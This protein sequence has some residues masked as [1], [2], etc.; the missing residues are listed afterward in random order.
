M[1]Y[2]LQRNFKIGDVI[3]FNDG[4]D[5]KV[6][7][8]A[9]T[10]LHNGYHGLADLQLYLVKYNNK[11][12]YASDNGLDSRDPW[13]FKEVIAGIGYRGNINYKSFKKE[14]NIWKDIIYRCYN[15]NS[16]LYPYYGG[17]EVTV[18]NKW[19]CFEIFL[20]DIINLK[21]Y[22][23]MIRDKSNTVWDLDI[24]KQRDIPINQ[25]S[26]NPKGVKLE[27]FFCTDAGAVLKRLR[28]VGNNSDANSINSYQDNPVKPAEPKKYEPLSDS[29]YPLEA[30]TAVINNPPDLPI[31]DMEVLPPG[32][33]RTFMGFHYDNRPPIKPITSPYSK[34]NGK[35][36]CRIIK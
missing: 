34:A 36:M 15:P 21:E 10:Y 35:P 9:G 24:T 11:K 3:T 30:Y 23:K 28:K 19:L 13:I 6:L 18:C 14:Y 16:A 17:S 12:Y 22:D 33:I 2:N 31:P 25:R 8:Y 7:N 29:S 4:I 26:Y 1:K 5:V 20:S 27:P 32:V